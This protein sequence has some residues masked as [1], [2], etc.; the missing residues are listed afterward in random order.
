MA[1]GS[2]GLVVGLSLLMSGPTKV[3]ADDTGT[4]AKEGGSAAKAPN[5]A[6]QAGAA[7]KRSDAQVALLTPGVLASLPVLQAPSKIAPAAA[8][9]PSDHERIRQLEFKNFGAAYP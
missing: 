4:K 9:L 7:S 6:D 1:R 5:R 8:A 3:K 2:F